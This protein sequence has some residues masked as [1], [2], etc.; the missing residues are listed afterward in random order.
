M[1]HIE[2]DLDDEELDIFMEMCRQG[3]YRLSQRLEMYE[4]ASFTIHDVRRARD[5]VI[6][7]QELIQRMLEPKI[8]T[9]DH[10]RE[11]S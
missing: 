4:K 8:W 3:V 6:V 7:A 5:K 9:E 1:K 10:P 2:I 11:V